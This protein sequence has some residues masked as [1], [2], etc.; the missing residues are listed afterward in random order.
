MPKHTKEAHLYEFAKRG[1]EA[2]LS[3]L[4]KEVKLLVRLFPHLR[5][6]FEQDDLPLPFIIATHSGGR[7]KSP[8]AG[9]RNASAAARRARSRRM[10][11]SWARRKATKA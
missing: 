6:S 7:T 8:V 1:A 9:R 5:D 11:S 2:R 10:K 3:E 4:V